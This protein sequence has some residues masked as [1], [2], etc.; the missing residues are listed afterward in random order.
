MTWAI[1]N[2]LIVA[3]NLGILALSLKLYTEI[4]KDQSQNRRAAKGRTKGGK[5]C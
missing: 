1:V 3:V 4:L 5:P 2:I